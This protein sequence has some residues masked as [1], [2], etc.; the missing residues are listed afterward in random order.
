MS[1]DELVARARAVGLDGIC[2]TEH[3]RQR[4][5]YAAELTV[6]YGIVVIGALEASVELGDILCFGID[7]FPRTITRAEELRDYVR[8][9]GGV[10][11][12]AHPFRYDLSP[13]PWLR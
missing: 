2:V 7:H 5:P 13:K 9:A 12:A 6:K 3:G 10:M 4:F 11:V 1:P 8:G